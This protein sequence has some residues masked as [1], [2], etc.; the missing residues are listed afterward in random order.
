MI[1][2]GDPSAQS[3]KKGDAWVA[4]ESDMYSARMILCV[5]HRGSVK[6]M[7]SEALTQIKSADTS[8]LVDHVLTNITINHH[9]QMILSRS[10]SCWSLKGDSMVLVSSPKRLFSKLV[11]GTKRF[12]IITKF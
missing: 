4:L 1:V 3:L 11:P 7:V 12:S 9:Y 5:A 2:V 10:S 8:S 6:A